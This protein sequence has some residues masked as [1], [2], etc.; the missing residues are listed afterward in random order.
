MS[1]KGPWVRIPPSPPAT[2]T[3]T[4]ALRRPSFSNM[5]YVLQKL[6][7]GDLRSIGR[8]NEVVQDVLEDPA[9]LAEGFEGL[10][11]DDPR[12]RVRSADGL[13]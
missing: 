6:Q 9:L 7:G 8:S 12:G 10:F 4:T 3:S 1:R 11:S 13:A 2:H 5:S